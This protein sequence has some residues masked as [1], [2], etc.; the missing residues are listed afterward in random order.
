M[1]KIHFIRKNVIL[2]GL[3]RL[4]EPGDG[5]AV[6]LSKP[7]AVLAKPV[8]TRERAAFDAAGQDK[9]NLVIQVFLPCFSHDGQRS[10]KPLITQ[11]FGYL[12]IREQLLPGAS[13]ENIP[14]TY[15]PD[16]SRHL[17]P[18][19]QVDVRDGE[20][21][22]D[23]P[24]FQYLAQLA[25]RIHVNHLRFCWFVLLVEVQVFARR[26]A[27]HPDKSFVEPGIGVKTVLEHHIDGFPA[28]CDLCQSVVK[29]PL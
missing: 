24:V 29:A 3:Q 15:V 4:V 1:V 22:I 25:F 14:V 6:L 2:D 12:Q 8:G 20:T 19:G 18:V 5:P 9:N 28:G 23:I 26:A 16:I 13:L 7:E 11:S 17:R 27:I 21:L 10:I